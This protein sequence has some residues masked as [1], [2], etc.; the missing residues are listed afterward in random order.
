MLLIQESSTTEV[1]GAP[2]S[3]DYLGHSSLLDHLATAPLRPAGAAISFFHGF[4]RKQGEECAR[5]CGGLMW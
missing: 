3:R 5:T 2:S 1:E 4:L